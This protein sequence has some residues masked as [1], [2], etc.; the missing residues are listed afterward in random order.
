MFPDFVIFSITKIPYTFDVLLPF[1]IFLVSRNAVRIVYRWY[2]V[3]SWSG[4]D[5]LL[6]P[7]I[8]P[9]PRLVVAKC[10]TLV[11]HILF[12]FLK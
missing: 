10:V 7:K 12:L 11:K 6:F 4:S 9:H 3:I 1:E 8:P 2:P 5:Y